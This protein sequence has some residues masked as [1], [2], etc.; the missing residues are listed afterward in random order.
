MKVAFDVDGTLI[1][2]SDRPRWHVIELLKG[3]HAIGQT[4]VVWS[5]GGH[6]YARH[7]VQRLYLEDFVDEI[8]CKPMRGDGS[9]LEQLKKEIDICFDDERVDLA[10][11]SV[12]V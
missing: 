1:T 4:V 7:W 3:F 8:R 5:G 12:K 2:F 10:K 9:D 11:V 6:D